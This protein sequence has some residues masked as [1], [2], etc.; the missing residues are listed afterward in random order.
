MAKFKVGD[1]VV[2]KS[3]TDSGIGEVVSVE[4]DEYSF[5]DHIYGV[6]WTEKGGENTPAIPFRNHHYLEKVEECTHYRNMTGPCPACGVEL[7]VVADSAP[8]Q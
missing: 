1:K 7:P 8:Q 4:E 3:H 6:A 2:N 5:D